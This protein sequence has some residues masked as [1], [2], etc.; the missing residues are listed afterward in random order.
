VNRSVMVGPTEMDSSPKTT[1]IVAYPESLSQQYRAE[2]LWR[3]RTIAQ[4]FHASAEAFGEKVALLC[5]GVK[6]TYAHLDRL[7]DKVAVG[8]WESGLRPGER[9]LLQVTN[10]PWTVLAWYGLL[11]AGLIPV[12]TL[13]QHRRHDILAIARQCEPVAHLIEPDFP[14]HDLRTLAREV[15][16]EQPSIRSRLT[17]GVSDPAHDELSIE[18]LIDRNTDQ[19]SD[20]RAVERAQH[21][22]EPDSVAVLQLS[23]GT[24]SVPKLIPRLHSEYW[25]NSRAW[26]AAMGL[27]AESCTIHLLP[28]VH[29]AGIVC[30]LHAAHAV[31]ATFATCTP[32][33]SQFSDVAAQKTITHMLMTRPIARV[34]AADPELRQSLNGL[35]MIAWADRTVP[36]DVVEQYESSTCTV[37]QMFGMG[38]GLCMI[39]PVGVSAEVRHGTQGTPISHLDEVRVLQPGTDN[40]VAP[41]ERG[42]LCARGPYTIRGYYRAPERNAE[43]FTAD[44]FYRT[45]DIVSEVRR[46]GSS[47][48]RLEDRIKDLIN[49]GG[50]K[51]NAEEVEEL[52]L[53]HPA[54]ERAAVVAMPDERLG[55]RS[56]AFLVSRPGAVTPD[57]DA[58]KAFLDQL[59][60]AKFKWP[61]RIELREELP[62]TNIHKIN[63]VALRLEISDLVRSEQAE[64]PAGTSAEESATIV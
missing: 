31:G 35:K 64:R 51:I 49:R 55:E 23:G 34:I 53:R 50:E 19:D 13:A 42:E 3:N 8:L 21:E 27:D 45:G 18:S 30:S 60:V 54:V 2:G 5:P 46:G 22:I 14:G 56:C 4:E 32:D 11:K 44:G 40:P 62:L 61:E 1:D 29:N 37:T 59:G 15:A 26:A 12:A 39:T 58:V 38:E 36:A 33:S 25:Y 48:Y 63:K 17:A 28:I 16:R 6:L 43:A 57:I 24:T 41:G 10:R 9:V 52:L 47:F 20:C 7:T